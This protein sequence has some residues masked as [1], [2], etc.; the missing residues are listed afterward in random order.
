MV[1]IKEKITELELII[2]QHKAIV[3]QQEEKHKYLVEQLKAITS[4][5]SR[6]SDNLSKFRLLKKNYESDIERLDF[7]EQSHNFTG[8][9]V[10]VK[11]PICNSIMK[12]ET[13]DQPKEIYFIAIDKEKQKLKI[14]LSDLVD[15]I[16]DLESDLTDCTKEADQKQNSIQEIEKYLQA[17]SI[18]ISK[19]LSDY[20]SFLKIRDKVVELRVGKKKYL[21]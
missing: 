1:N 21:I 17:Q 5:K 14:H 7:I 20:E 6:I 19:T 18:S 3:E 4:E 11:C 8:Q 12:E 13:S 16:L 10:S 9:L 2:E 15:T